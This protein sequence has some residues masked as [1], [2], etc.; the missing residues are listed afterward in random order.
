MYIASVLTL[1]GV[2]Q[3]QIISVGAVAVGESKSVGVISSGDGEMEGGAAAIDSTDASTTVLAEVHR[4]T[5]KRLTYCD[6]SKKERSPQTFTALTNTL[7]ATARQEGCFFLRKLKVPDTSVP[8]EK[9]KFSS[10]SD[11]YHKSKTEVLSMW[12]LTVLGLESESPDYMHYMSQ[13]VNILSPVSSTVRLEG[14][15]Q[16]E[17]KSETRLVPETKP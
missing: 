4:V 9:R 8:G 3:P 14:V 16:I 1:C 17:E 10:I 2:L 5:K 7:V 6:W 11:D 15:D 13:A 12:L